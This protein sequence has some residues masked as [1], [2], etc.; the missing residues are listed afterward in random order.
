MLLSRLAKYQAITR[1]FQQGL[2]TDNR[3]IIEAHTQASRLYILEVERR[4]D[5]PIFLCYVDIKRT[6]TA[7]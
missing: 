6:N 5:D 4:A 2:V 3:R 7:T 1:R